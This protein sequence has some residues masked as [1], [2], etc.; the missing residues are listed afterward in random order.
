MTEQQNP[1]PD[2]SAAPVV[3]EPAPPVET[4]PPTLPKGA[5]SSGYAVYDKT[6]AR[7][8]T[9]VLS[10][11]DA[12]KAAASGPDGHTLTVVKV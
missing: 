8:T 5:E 10:K 12:D 1:T 2:P 7:F 9:G 4:E 11:A 3:T 6:L